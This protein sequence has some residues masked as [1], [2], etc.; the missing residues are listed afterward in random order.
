[1]IANP[2]MPM[3]R[4][5]WS[6]CGRFFDRVTGEHKSLFNNENRIDEINPSDDC[7]KKADEKILSREPH[8]DSI[9]HQPQGLCATSMVTSS[10]MTINQRDVE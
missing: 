2:L 8:A 3:A 4:R 9:L 10:I 7:K 6:D 1:M 5:F